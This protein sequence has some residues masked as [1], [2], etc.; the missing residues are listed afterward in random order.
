MTVFY[1]EPADGA[2]T[3]LGWRRT[4]LREGCWVQAGSEAEARAIVEFVT[5]RLIT[6]EV[7]WDYTL[8]PW[9]DPQLT[10]CH[11]DAPEIGVPDGVVVT[12]SGRAI[13]HDG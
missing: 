3:E 10:H 2:T 6:P 12:V 11:P 5:A 7:G 4:T 9:A 8:S 1:L 13:S